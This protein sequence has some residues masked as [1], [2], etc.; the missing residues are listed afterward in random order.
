M[1][2]KIELWPTHACTRAGASTQEDS[3]DPIHYLTAYIRLT[4]VHW[5]QCYAILAAL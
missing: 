4:A 5:L 1:I 3:T 2:L